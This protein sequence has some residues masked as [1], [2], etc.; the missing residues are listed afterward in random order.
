MKPR[1]ALGCVALALASFPAAQ[2]PAQSPVPTGPKPP[3]VMS[4]SRIT[5]R[6]VQGN[7]ELT[8]ITSTRRSSI[9]YIR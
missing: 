4:C 3:V 2:S 8:R 7:R 1:L 5:A 6:F 9:I